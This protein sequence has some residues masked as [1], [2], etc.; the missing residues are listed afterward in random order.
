M[1]IFCSL[2]TVSLPEGKMVGVWMMLGDFDGDFPLWMGILIGLYG[3]WLDFVA[4]EWVI[5]RG[6]SITSTI[7]HGCVFPDHDQ[8]CVPKKH[9]WFSSFQKGFVRNSQKWGATPQGRRAGGEPVASQGHHVDLPKSESWRFSDEFG[10]FAG[11]MGRCSQFRMGKGAISVLGNFEGSLE[12]WICW[13][14]SILQL[15]HRKAGIIFFGTRIWGW[16]ATCQTYSAIFRFRF[17]SINSS[18]FTSSSRFH[19]VWP[20]PAIAF[21]VCSLCLLAMCKAEIFWKFCLVRLTASKRSAEAAASVRKGW[22]G[23]R[24]LAADGGPGRAGTHWVLGH[25]G[26]LASK[27]SCWSTVD[28]EVCPQGTTQLWRDAEY[29]R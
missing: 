6:I 18:N 14:F 8:G 26:C 29:L 2:Q 19:G 20:I 17:T 4:R 3:N 27:V 10:N 23:W 1:V 25:D 22:A 12:T 13:W 9:V 28:V 21:A 5:L 16:I 11:N 24:S 15:I 7:K